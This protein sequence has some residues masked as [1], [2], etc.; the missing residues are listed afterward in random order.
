MDRFHT[1]NPRSQHLTNTSHV[2]YVIYSLQ[3]SY[4]IDATIIPK[5]M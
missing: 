5:N 3:Q 2:H 1:Y 4:K